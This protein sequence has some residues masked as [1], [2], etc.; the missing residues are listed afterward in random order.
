MENAPFNHTPESSSDSKESKKSKKKNAESIGAFLVESK[1]ERSKEGAKPSLW[2][3]PEK[4]A[5]ESKPNKPESLEVATGQEADERSAPLEHLSDEEKQYAVKAIVAESQVNPASPEAG[6]EAAAAGEA[7]VARFREAI[8]EED[9]DIDAAEESALEYVGVDTA[10]LPD[11]LVA[12]SEA[13]NSEDVTDVE[14]EVEDGPIEFD[15]DAAIELNAAE[16]DSED[17]E[18]AVGTTPPAAPAAGTAGTG[19]GGHGHG[20]AGAPP[21]PPAPP[22]GGGGG[23]IP[24]HGPAG[25]PFGAAHGPGGPGGPGVAPAAVVAPVVPAERIIVDHGN[26]AAAALLGG[27]IGYFIGR[28]RGRIKTEKRLM[29]IQKKL[30][31]EV[32]DLQ[33]QVQAKEARIRKLAAEQARARGFNQAEADRVHEQQMQKNKPERQTERREAPRNSVELAAERIMN[34]GRQ[35]Y[36]E[37]RKPAAEAQQLHGTHEAPTHLGHMVMTAESHR[38]SQKGQEQG[39]DAKATGIE[40]SVETLNRE[41]LLRMAEKIVVD[42]SSLRQIYETKL[43]G[44]RGLRRLVQEH[45]RGGDLKKALRREVI[46]REIDFERDP[47]M[48]DLVTHDPGP[49]T[50]GGTTPN[51]KIHQLLQKAEVSSEVNK[52]EIAFLKARASFEA[53]QQASKQ[54]RRRAMD[55]SMVTIIAVL[56]GLVA[57][58]ILRHQ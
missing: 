27:I 33:W 3:S 21:A 51:D 39:I 46:E 35:E 38:R 34:V 8:L 26:E 4:P 11:E 52:E 28:R 41:E 40:K 37:G 2:K 57:I 56:F 7:A 31:K 14:S 23:G 44:E 25:V 54:R 12:E 30:K 18:D 45:L 47:A 20:G 43:V 32:S 6:D 24:P 17:D 9:Q 55:I 36:A 53:K 49:V 29:P 5:G 22:A 48:R 16:T 19:A 42:G 1:S 50:G 15:D 13:E 10:E 58:L